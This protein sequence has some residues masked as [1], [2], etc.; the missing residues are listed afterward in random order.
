[1]ATLELDAATAVASLDIFDHLRDEG[2]GEL[3]F[4]VDPISGLNA[5]IAIH[6]TKRGPALGGCRFVH[7]D[8]S[9]AAITDAMRLAKGMS[10]KAAVCGLPLGGG[11]AVILKPAKI[12][13]RPALFR[14]FGRFVQDLGGRYITA[15]DS[16]TQLTDMDIAAEVTPYVASKTHMGQ[17]NDDGDPAPYTAK[18]TF[19]GLEAIVKHSLKRSDLKGLRV[20]IQG[21]G[22]VGYPLAKALHEAGA[23][24]WVADVNT[25]ATAR[26][27]KEFGAKVVDFHEIHRVDCD[28]LSPCALG[29]TLNDHT[30]PEIQAKV[31][32]GCANNQLAEDRHGQMLKDLKIAYAPDFVINAGGLIHAATQYLHHSDAKAAQHIENIYDAIYTICERAERLNQPTNIIANQLAE[33]R[34]K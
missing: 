22:A 6:S 33:E 7:Y 27:E 16:G 12:A 13:D 18:G 15:L 4:R 8:S 24:L 31:I 26:C 17:N 25:E 29:A 34:L 21:V 10:Y 2:F 23:S 19:R 30:I 20:A 32:A 3:H 9:Q 14:A 11:K 28:I 1:M 5:I